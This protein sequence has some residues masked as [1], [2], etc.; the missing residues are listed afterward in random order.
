MNNIKYLI[1]NTNVTDVAIYMA[2]EY[3]KMYSDDI[4]EMKLH[5]LMYFAQRESIIQTGSA[6][7][8][9]TFYGWKF[10]PVL[11]EVRSLYKDND[12]RPTEVINISGVPANII[13]STLERY[14]GWESWRLS[15]L[16]H[17]ELS[18]RMSRRGLKRDESGNK[19]ILLAH[20]LIDAAR[21]K[22]YRKGMENQ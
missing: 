4:D 21:V 15:D 14:G 8:D 10:G 17:S 3:R 1:N 16:S 13:N 7:V 11:K 12:H 18:W 22:E 5:K 2:D 6:L 20:I 19:P 9:A